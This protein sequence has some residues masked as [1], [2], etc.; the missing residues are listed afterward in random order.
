MNPEIANDP[1]TLLAY[2]RQFNVVGLVENH[3]RM[4]GNSAPSSLLKEQIETMENHLTRGR[5]ADARPS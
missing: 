1:N 3:Y 2:L 4:Y 5:T